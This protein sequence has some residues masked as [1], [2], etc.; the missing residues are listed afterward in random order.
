MEMIGAWCTRARCA[1]AHALPR[2]RWS[3][4]LCLVLV[5]SGLPPGLWARTAAEAEDDA[6]WESVRGCTDAVE[7]ELYVRQFTEGGR[8]LEEA[9]AC[10][11]KL[12]KPPPPD[13]EAV[14]AEVASGARGAGVGAA[15][16]RGAGLRAACAGRDVRAENA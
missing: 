16:A 6:F 9:R 5:A 13:P 3:W 7:V 4:C 12:W 8:H 14:E 1:V 15:R 10:L 11:A 2:E